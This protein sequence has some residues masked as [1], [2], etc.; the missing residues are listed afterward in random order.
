MVGEDQR[1]RAGNEARDAIRLH[2]DGIAE[3]ELRVGQK[4][5]AIG[6]E[7]DVLARGEECD[8]C[9]EPCDR[10]QIDAR[11]ERTEHRNAHEQ[12]DLRNQHPPAPAAQHRQCVAVHQ[13]RPQEFP[14]IRELHQ[15]EEADRCQID[16]LGAQPRRQKIDEQPQR[17]AGRKTGEHADQHPPVEDRV[18]P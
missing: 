3:P 13:R 11:I 18:A 15:R 5:A 7:H 12:R 14:R 16:L 1:E 6:I 9:R 2:M 4:L 8:R 17:E 10:P